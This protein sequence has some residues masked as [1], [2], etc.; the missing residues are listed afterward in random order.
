MSNKPR[1]RINIK[2]H[3]MQVRQRSTVKGNKGTI[4]KKWQPI[5]GKRRK[6]HCD[7]PRENRL[8][9]FCN[10]KRAGYYC[11]KYVDSRYACPHLT[12]SYH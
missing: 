10:H 12:L 7:L 3:Y 2:G 8:P 9:G 6:Y 1:K 11:L 4:L 5:T